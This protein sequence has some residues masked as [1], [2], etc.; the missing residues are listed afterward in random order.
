MFTRR[1]QV[2]WL[3]SELRIA[4]G[5]RSPSRAKKMAL[6]ADLIQ[7]VRDTTE[8]MYPSLVYCGRIVEHS[9][10]GEDKHG[11]LIAL[12]EKHFQDALSKLLAKGNKSRFY[13]L[14][15]T[16]PI[17]MRPKLE[18]FHISLKIKV[19]GYLNIHENALAQ[20]VYI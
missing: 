5:K 12:S 2:Q 18:L 16:A 7:M 3:E 14:E 15:E 1:D 9:E 20:Y 6:I 11:Y 13:R 10:Q 19:T 17:P 4:D 8:P